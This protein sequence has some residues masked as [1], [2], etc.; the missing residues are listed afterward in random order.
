MGEP[1]DLRGGV[2]AAAVG[3][4]DHLVRQVVALDPSFDFT[5][6]IAVPRFMGLVL[7]PARVRAGAENEI[8]GAIHRRRNA[9]SSLPR[10]GGRPGS[11]TKDWKIRSMNST[12]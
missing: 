1:G 3:V 7:V 6:A 9:R 11:M 12:N 10:C 2:L 8:A 4:Q 5:L